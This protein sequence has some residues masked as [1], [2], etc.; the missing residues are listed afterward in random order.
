MIRAMRFGAAGMVLVVAAGVFGGPPLLCH[1]LDIG[2]AKSIPRDDGS[3][4]LSNEAVMD[5]ANNVLRTSEDLVVHIET[6][7]RAAMHL[8]DARGSI[9]EF[10]ADTCARA[11]D[12][13]TGPDRK[14]AARAWFDAAYLTAVRVEMGW[15]RHEKRDDR[16]GL[17]AGYA[18]LRRA[19]DMSEGAVPEMHLA[20]AMM[21]IDR[22]ADPK[23][24]NAKLFGDHAR[25]MLEGTKPG[26]LL[27]KNAEG[28]FKHFGL[29]PNDFRGARAAVSD[30]TVERK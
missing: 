28:W 11:L 12:A 13:E 10:Y 17:P 21:L 1:P 7:R 30:R 18:W 26:S 15:D 14:V 27:A 3:A 5:G 24:E 25:K 22:R 23:G 8:G 16:T 6:I 29:N 4:R 9:T 20:A 2:D 19:I